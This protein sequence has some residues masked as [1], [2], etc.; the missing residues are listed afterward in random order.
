M[1]SSLCLFTTIENF[2]KNNVYDKD[3]I[4]QTKQSINI[5]KWTLV[6]IKEYVHI[7]KN[8]I[9]VYGD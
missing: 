1:F 8:F 7:V 6:P 5:N 9:P 4:Q 3:M 2:I